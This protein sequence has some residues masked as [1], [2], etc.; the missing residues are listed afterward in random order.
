MSG[1]DPTHKVDDSNTRILIGCLVAIIAILM[2]IIVIILW[3]QVWQ[4]MLEK[5]RGHFI[6]HIIRLIYCVNLIV[7]GRSNYI[8][9]RM[10]DVKPCRALFLFLFY[11][12]YLSFRIMW[13]QLS[14]QLFRKSL[15]WPGSLPDDN[16]IRLDVACCPEDWLDVN[17][18]RHKLTHFLPQASRRMLDDELTARLAVQTQAFASHHSSLSSDAS[19]TTNSTYERIFPLC[20]DYQEPSRLIR[21]LPEFTKFTEHLG[22]IKAQCHQCCEV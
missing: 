7:L 21:K 6:R 15:C 19:S 5:V 4:K 12:N 17:K 14:V 18:K 1:D 20:A 22:R 16:L 2:T 11:V 3:R 13:P 8:L 9:H 10:F